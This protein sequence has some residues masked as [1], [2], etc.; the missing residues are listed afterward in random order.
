MPGPLDGYRIIEL[1]GI[2]PAPFAAMILSDLGA[3]VIRVDRADEARRPM[4]GATR[5]VLHRGR[6]SLAVDL[7]QPGGAETV[8]RLAERADALLEGF[9]PG[10][11]ERMGVGPDACMAR[12]PRLVY[13]RMT[14]WGQEG[15][16][17]Q[18]PGHD[19]NFIA[20][21]GVLDSLARDGDVPYPPLNLVGDFGGGAMFMVCGIIAALLEVAKSGVGQ[22]VDA[23]MVD[24]AAVLMSMFHGYVAMGAWNEQRG[25]NALDTGSHFYEVYETSDGK[26]VSIGAAEPKFYAE[27]LA[28]LGLD[29]PV[30]Q[31][32]DQARWP[33][34]K[35]R[36]RELFATRTRD[37]WCEIMEGAETCFAPVLSM[38]EAPSHPHNQRRGTF[39]ERHGVVQPAPAP[40]FSRTGCEIQRAPARPGEH[41][42]EI[43]AEQG[44]LD[45]EIARLRDAGVIVDTGVLDADHRAAA[46][47]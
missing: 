39:V 18:S 32:M 45:D 28:R 36:L 41:S 42:A 10:V 2:G 38:R 4:E 26:F 16:L 35:T 3:E 33:A 7:K 29:D 31:Q 1:A 43:L 34:M 21:A 47:R 24:G 30:D 15:P 11:T 23:A 6:R 25:T 46:R 19:I 20:V 44:F 17:A 37:E 5:N 8:L 12:N 14:G 27:L 13:G 22:V 40:R 9:R